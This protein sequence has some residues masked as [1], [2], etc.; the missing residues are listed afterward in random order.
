[1]WRNLI[2]RLIQ[3]GR[4]LYFLPFTYIG[5]I[6]AQTTDTLYSKFNEKISL[7]IPAE[8]NILSYLN[9]DLLYVSSNEMLESKNTI[10]VVSLTKKAILTKIKLLSPIT[11]NYSVSAFAVSNEAMV[12]VCHDL[13]Y[14]YTLKKSKATL[15]KTIKNPK[16]FLEVDFMNHNQIIVLHKLYNF[17]PSDQKIC[18]ENLYIHTKDFSENDSISFPY[19]GIAYSHQIHQWQLFKSNE[20]DSYLALTNAN[21]IVHFK[22]GKINDTIQLPNHNKFLLPDSL[23]LLPF[24]GKQMVQFLMQ[25]DSLYNR[26][27][28]LFLKN[29]TLIVSEIFK[30]SKKDFRLLTYCY[31]NNGNWCFKS[32]IYQNIHGLAEEKYPL[33]L[34]YSVPIYFVQNEV[35]SLIQ[36]AKERKNKKPI[37]GYGLFFYELQN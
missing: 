32:I 10:W 34:S 35:V 4:I 28:K 15:V 24:R 37:Y 16:S 29:D 22:Q 2:Y 17:H 25:K 27:E 26:I 9:D 7:P 1:M 33:N 6:E 19:D 20:F 11:S 23:L 18:C 8:H 3:K 14:F 21:A 5:F 31:K 36:F 13:I 30:G 12:F